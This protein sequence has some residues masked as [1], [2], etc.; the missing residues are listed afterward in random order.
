MRFRLNWVMV[1][2]LAVLSFSVKGQPSEI[3][4]LVFEGAGIRGIAY[5]G[6][7]SVLEEQG[8][9][10]GIEKIG[11]T[12]S[13]AITALLFSL[14]YSAAE[15]K[16]IISQTKFQKFN[17]GRF[18]FIGGIFRTKKKYGWYRGKKFIE[19]ISDLIEAKTGDGDMTFEALHQRGYKDVYFTA[20]CLNQQQLIILSHETYPK[21]KLKDAV[22]ISMSIPL[23]FQAVFVDSIGNIYSSQD[24]NHQLDVMID[25]GVVANFPVQIFDTIE[26]DSLGNEQRTPNKYT[27]GIKIDSDKQIEEDEVSK[28]LI[29]QVI[30]NFSDY[31]SAF[32]LIVIENLNR[33]QLKEADWKRTVFVSSVGI[34][35]KIK[36]LTKDQKDKLIESGRSSME[37]FFGKKISSSY[38]NFNF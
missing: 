3:K 21:M 14:G 18:F 32:Y 10:D 34:S 17:D 15:T 35:P 23:Y 5:S 16:D 7:L 29:P 37:R 27:L 31:L 38:F 20:T 33:M 12:S 28:R 13:G 4:N 22:R 19:W 25:G 1:L 6:V 9:R 24:R 8:I 11:G 30:D 26:V 36:K 2:S